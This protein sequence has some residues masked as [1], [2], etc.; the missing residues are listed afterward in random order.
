M[1]KD[2]DKNTKLASDEKDWQAKAA[3]WQAEA[4][5]W[6]RIAQRLA[7]ENAQLQLKNNQSLHTEV[8]HTAMAKAV[9]FALEQTKHPRTRIVEKVAAAFDVSERTVERALAEESK[10]FEA[11]KRK[12]PRRST[13]K[14]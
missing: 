4:E 5:L 12:E 6:M 2:D 10:K 13:D 3:T 11:K 14:L 8:E 1:G 9:A 7:L